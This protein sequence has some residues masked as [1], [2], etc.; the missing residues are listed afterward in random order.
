MK[1]INTL[2]FLG[3]VLFFSFESGFSAEFHENGS[4]HQRCLDTTWPHEK[5]DLVPD[6]AL[7]FGRLDNGFRYILLKNKEP[8]GRVGVYLDIQAGSLYETA[9]QR[10]IAHFLEHMVFNGSTHFPP[11]SLVDYF[12]SIGMSFGGDTNAHTSFDETVYNIL[13]PGASR[14]EMNKGLLVMADYARGALLS[15][16]EINRERGVILSEKRARDSVEYRSQKAGMAFSMRGSLVPER[17]PI[18]VLKTLSKADHGTMKAFYDAWYRPEKMILVMVGD[19]D[20]QLAESLVRDR[21]KGLRGEGGAPVCP[22]LGQVNHTGTEFFYHHEPE[23]GFTEVTIETV[24]N[25][26]EGNDSLALQRREVYEAA[27]GLI[28][29]HR[30]ERL[31]EEKD[32]PFTEGVAHAGMF[33]GQIGYGMI[34]AKTDPGKWQ[35]TLGTIEQ[36]LR[37]AL[38]YGFTEQELKRVKKEMLSELDSAVL[39]AATRDSQKL[40]ADLISRLNG[41]KVLMS[42]QQEK[43]VLSP[44]IADMKAEELHA[45]FQRI[46]NHQA[47]LIQV[48]GNVDLSGADPRSQIKG[49]YE[50]FSVQK[51]N[52][53]QAT[54]EL[55]FPYL[56]LA[57]DTRP[58]REQLLPEVQAERIVFANGVIVN[59]KQTKFQENEVQVA[60]HFGNGRQG[61]PRPGLALLAERVVNDSG[62]GKFTRSDLERILAGSTVK[63]DFKVNEASF[64]WKGAAVNK[65]VEL[66]FQLLQAQ[67]ADPA[68]REDAY[69]KAMQGFKQMYEQMASDVSGAMELSG[70]SFLA[71]GNKSFGLPSWQDFAVLTPD[72]IRAWVQPAMLSGGLEVSLVGDFD[73]Q[74][75]RNLAR[76]YLAPLAK[77]EQSESAAPQIHFPAGETLRLTAPSSID[78]AMLVVAWPTADFWDIERTRRLYLL[79]EVF[80]DRL[81]KV[82][83]EKLGATYSPQVFSQPSRIYPGYGVL[84]AELIVAPDHI[85]TLSREVVLVASDL[86]K[87][88][89]S[90][91]ELERAKAPML[92]SL[93][94]M[95]RTN[96]YWLNSVLALSSRYPQQLQWPSTI[97]SAFE[98]VTREELSSLAREYL[99]PAQAAKVMV[100]PVK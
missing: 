94:D 84:R 66:L 62:T 79:T 6:P 28:V 47:R 89:V 1:W 74:R 36:V 15:E 12:Q 69:S 78:K 29:Q 39:T 72:Q 32:T 70:E 2:L 95:V 22:D 56:H 98:S 37:Q 9:G 99:D 44:V 34:S 81:R 73:L 8:K 42:P 5:S 50:S 33:L 76:E 35:L 26:L 46:W 86:W 38:K 17:M 68:V 19:F 63:L 20:P 3:L 7:I 93:K 82:I 25:E 23:M 54:T 65:D 21:F 27:A 91:E 77:R 30:L 10:G 67:L 43:D 24:W 96:G 100:V 55:V 13:L 92:T 16:T 64:S 85:E 97:L 59:L 80:S 45:A 90:A 61:E 49:S 51:V 57:A 60:A 58:A 52:P 53:P 4:Q 87:S 18:G 71:G 83:R 41:N 88:G 31:L 48:V 14:E 40:A 75:V 11:G